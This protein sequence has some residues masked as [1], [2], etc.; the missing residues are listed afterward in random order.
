MAWDTTDTLGKADAV[1]N[2]SLANLLKEERRFAPPAD[3]AANANVTA[4]AY[5]QAKADR[6]G[7]FGCWLGTMV[8]KERGA[9]RSFHELYVRSET[10]LGAEKAL[11][12]H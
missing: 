10:G 2:E 11:P 4:E 1:S 3:L 6:L 9:E 7:F 5:E 8:S 12:G